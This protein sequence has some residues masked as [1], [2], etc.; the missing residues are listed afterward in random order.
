MQGS[1]CYSDIYFLHDRLIVIDIAPAYSTRQIMLCMISILVL[2]FAMGYS[3]CCTRN[4]GPN[5]KPS[6]S[7]YRICR[8]ELHHKRQID[9]IENP[10][11]TEYGV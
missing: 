10:E 8:I 3:C 9:N 7:I 2:L 6:Q 4:H 11:N 5:Q 1:F